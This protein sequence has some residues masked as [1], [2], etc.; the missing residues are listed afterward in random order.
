MMEKAGSSIQS[1]LASGLG[2]KEQVARMVELAQ[3]NDQ[4]LAA[5]FELLRTGNK[6]E[7]GTAAEVMKF[8]SKEQPERMAPYIPVL[9]DHIDYPAPR[10]RWGCPEAL[11][12]L[13]AHYP[14]QV[15]QAIPKLLENLADPSTVVRWCAAY[16]L[17][18]IA[19]SNLEKQAELVDRF[20]GLIQTEPNSGVRKVYLK[21]LKLIAKQQ[22][23]RSAAGDGE[24][25]G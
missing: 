16:A 21:A 5:L 4:A 9:I 3:A 11:G 1:I 17:A 23:D 22:K 2:H 8:V 7:K 25:N 15:G 14:E 19:K 24:N 20:D 10:V 13:A 12:N 6:V 18:E